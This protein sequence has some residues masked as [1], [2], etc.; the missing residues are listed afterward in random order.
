MTCITLNRSRPH[1]VIPISIIAI[2][3]LAVMYTSHAV[4]KH[5]S[6]ADAV[7]RCLESKPPVLQMHN[8]ATGRWANIC[9]TESRYGIQVVDET[10]T[11]EITS[12]FDRH[13]TLD[14][15]VKYLWQA[16]Y[17]LP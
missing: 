12:F 7:R 5:G 8:P 9:W 17:S 6:D 16:G 4:E 15:V 2:I 1:S 13:K 11:K 10:Q 3:L 14:G